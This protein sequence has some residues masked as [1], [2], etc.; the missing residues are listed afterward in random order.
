MEEKNTPSPDEIADYYKNIPLPEDDN[1]FNE[2]I[3][4]INTPLPEIEIKTEQNPAENTAAGL[5]DE[6]PY[7]KKPVFV[8][9]TLILAAVLLI[10]SFVAG[11]TWTKPK[12]KV[13]S[14]YLE[15]LKTDSDY[16]KI[17]DEASSTLESL[18]KLKAERD[19]KQKEM[20]DLSK[21]EEEQAQVQQRIYEMQSQLEQLQS[22]IKAKQ[23]KIEK[24]DAEIE[25]KSKLTSEL[26]PGIYTVG[27]QIAPGQYTVT[28]DGALTVSDGSGGFRQSEIL[29]DE[30][31]ACTL[32]E[33]YVIKLETTAVFKPSE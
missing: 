7:R 30:G 18:D 1:K 12:S 13:D 25:K 15:L 16:L 20:D 33:G 21:F 29:S 9:V 11:R 24:T 14:L 22:D 8:I 3:S 31:T 23:S 26:T 2:I 32:E 28:G 6:M 4:E 19:E 27:K 10:A 17:H 5:V